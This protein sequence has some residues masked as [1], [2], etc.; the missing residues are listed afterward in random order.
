MI[1]NQGRFVSFGFKVSI[2]GMSGVIVP[3]RTVLSLPA[4]NRSHMR[5]DR[6][7]LYDGFIT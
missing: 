7:E 5:G 6:K 3:F 1:M 2:D 4:A